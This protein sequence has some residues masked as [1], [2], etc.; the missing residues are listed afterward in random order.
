MAKGGPSMSTSSSFGA[1]KFGARRR[2]GES[3]SSPTH[4]YPIARQEAV[5]KPLPADPAMALE[6]AV[7]A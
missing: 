4:Q 5:A 3:M 6:S 7:Q 1:L 2:D